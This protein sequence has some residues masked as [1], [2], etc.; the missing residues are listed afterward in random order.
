MLTP[1]AYIFTWIVF[2]RET[3]PLLKRCILQPG[4]TYQSADRGKH[5]GHWRCSTLFWV[6]PF[7]DSPPCREWSLGENMYFGFQSEQPFQS[8][9]VYY[10]P[11]PLQ[12][13]FWW[14]RERLHKQAERGRWG[15]LTCR[16]HHLTFTDRPSSLCT[17]CLA[18]GVW[19]LTWFTESLPK[20]VKWST[21]LMFDQVL[22]RKLQ[23][24]F[25]GVALKFRTEVVLC[26]CLPP[27]SVSVLIQLVM[28]CLLVCRI[29][30]LKKNP[31]E[32][33]H[34]ILI[35]RAHSLRCWFHAVHVSYVPEGSQQQPVFSSRCQPS[36]SLSD[37]EAPRNTGDTMRTRA[38]PLSLTCT[39]LVCCGISIFK[40]G[41][42]NLIGRQW[43]INP[44]I[45]E[46]VYS[47][48]TS[49][50]ARNETLAVLNEKG[51]HTQLFWS[52]H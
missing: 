39:P 47:Q 4:R 10:I 38:P 11:A 6:G 36:P 33:W 27:S 17:V 46:A 2:S 40:H 19:F 30:L 25:N 8:E 32:I 7:S 16:R 20:K 13:V 34:H 28:G 35:Q 3:F 9:A 24:V 5:S 52:G 29:Q 22:G 15:A 44:T 43:G 14:L 49:L 45:Y 12:Y 18:D 26:V 41:R 1:Q 31:N 23:R 48:F 42:P 51:K 50:A 37:T 21:C